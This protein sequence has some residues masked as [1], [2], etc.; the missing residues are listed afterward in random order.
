M[1]NNGIREHPAG[2]LNHRCALAG[3]PG[4]RSCSIQ[5]TKGV[6]IG[7][8][9]ALS[10]LQFTAFG[11]VKQWTAGGKT[12]TRSFNLDGEIV[13]ITNAAGTLTYTRDLAGQIV[14]RSD[15]E[16]YSYDAVGRLIGYAGSSGD[17]SFD[18]DLNGNRIGHLLGGNGLI[19]DYL[20]GNNQLSD[21][22]DLTNAYTYDAAGNVTANGTLTFTYDTWGRLVTVKQE[23]STKATYSY[24]A[25]SRSHALRGNAV[26]QRCSW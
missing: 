13:G 22:Q 7:G 23:A 3:A 24:N 19:F 21:I 11:P 26:W 4:F 10:N 16:G 12:Y 2:C 14:S 25:F 18:Y 8:A 6:N 15:G 20:N 5:A 9:T 1:K 17:Q